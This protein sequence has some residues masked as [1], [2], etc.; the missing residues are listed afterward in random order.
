M[1]KSVVF[2]FFIRDSIA[3]FI[4]LALLYDSIMNRNVN[5]HKYGQNFSF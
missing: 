2:P 5:N 1:C 4:A 3:A